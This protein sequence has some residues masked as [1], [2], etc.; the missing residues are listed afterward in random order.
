MCIWERLNLIGPAKK[1]SKKT[2]KIFAK[3]KRVVKEGWG[4]RGN[5]LKV[6]YDCVF[7][8]FMSYGAVA[9]YNKLNKTQITRHVLATPRT[10]FLAIL[11]ACK[12][13]STE[14]LQVIAGRMSLEVHFEKRAIEYR[15]GRGIQG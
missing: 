11:R 2:T 8:S 15:V 3:M 4:A 14:A 7:A 5:T 10:A 12:T 9:W 1:Q 6:L 13:V